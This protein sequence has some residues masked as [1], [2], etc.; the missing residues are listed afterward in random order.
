ME[1]DA[2]TSRLGLGQG[3]IAPANATPG[4]GNHVFVLGED[5]P[6]RFFDLAA[7]DHAEVVQDTDLTDVSLVRAHLRLRVPAN[8]PSTHG[9]EASIVVDGVKAARAT[10]RAGRE[11]LLTDLAANVSKLTGLHE[12]GV[13]LE[14][15]EV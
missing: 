15:V 6:G 13:R 4:S 10:C 14:L 5:E 8:L 12:V 2:F 11:R 7:G 3:R 1:L 9:W